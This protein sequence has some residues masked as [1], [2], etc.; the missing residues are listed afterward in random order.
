MTMQ[1]LA[2]Y[3]DSIT[4]LRDKM[5]VTVVPGWK[6]HDLFLSCCLIPSDYAVATSGLVIIF[7]NS[8]GHL[9]MTCIERTSID[10]CR[11]KSLR[12][13]LFCDLHS[14]RCGAAAEQ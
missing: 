14:Q 8:Y 9:G 11:N 2:V 3:Q 10:S 12:M 5:V 7:S 13:G 4:F 6:R 1:D